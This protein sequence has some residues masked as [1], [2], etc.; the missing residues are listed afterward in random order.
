MKKIF[1]I[2]ILLLTVFL[3]NSCGK[4]NNPETKTNDESKIEFVKYKC[5]NMHC[6]SCETTIKDAV[7][8]LDG[9]EEVT[10]D[11]KSKIV[12][13]SY[14]KD[15]TSKTDIEKTINEAGYDTETS[16]SENKHNCDME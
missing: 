13:V 12:K 6:E 8:K 1:L 11:A 15:K 7:K 10:A 4:K 5:N 3:L 16:K 2:S 9:I 14:N